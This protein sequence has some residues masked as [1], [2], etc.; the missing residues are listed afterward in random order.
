MTQSRPG[1]EENES[2]LNYGLNCLSHF[3]GAH[4]ARSLSPPFVVME[5]EREVHTYA[6]TTHCTHGGDARSVRAYVRS[7]SVTGGGE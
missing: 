2:K 4:G 1:I 6:Y 3:I 7:S 5:G